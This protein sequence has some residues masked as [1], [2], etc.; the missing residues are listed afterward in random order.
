MSDQTTP[1]VPQTRAGLANR[2]LLWGVGAAVRASLVVSPRPA[3]LL[4]RRVFASAGAQ[5]KAALDKHAPSDVVA[6]V[7]Q[8]YGDEDDMLLDVIR[9]ASAS[10]PLPLVLWVHG[11]GWVGGSKDELTGYF[12]IIAS[13]G[14]VVAGPRYALAPEQHYPTPPRQMMRALDYLQAN[15]ERLHIDPDR[16]AIAGDSAGAQIA[17][18]LAALITT[19]GYTERVGLTP[20]I[21]ARQLRGVVLACGPY[22]LGLAGQVSTP[23]GRRF[24]KAIMWAYSGN[25]TSLTTRSSQPGRSPTRSRPPSRRR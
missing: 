4:V 16:I 25:A 6:L 22:D 23:A 9:P 19:P 1:L 8:R 7:D 15:A 11:G 5:F 3:T 14:Y 20:A 17:A 10:G 13:N 24:I 18:Q 2:I 12:K 21:T